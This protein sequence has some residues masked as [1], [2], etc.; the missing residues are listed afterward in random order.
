MKKLSALLFIL[1]IPIIVL[2]AF[3]HKSLN[4]QV[5]WEERN[6][7]VTVSLNSVYNLNVLN[8]WT[9]GDNG[10][11]LHTTGRGYNW[12]NVSGGGREELLI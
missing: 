7:G 1:I 4:A 2:P 5:W 10:T 8:A 9:C 11:V 3:F 6:S 12:H